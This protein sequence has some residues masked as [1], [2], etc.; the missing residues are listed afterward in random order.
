MNLI[1]DQNGNV[2][3]LSNCMVDMPE[4]QIEQFR[5]QFPALTDKA[6]FNYGGQ[7][8]MP[9]GAIDAI[10]RSQEYIQQAGPFSKEVNS[11]I[12]QEGSRTRSMIAAELGVAPSTIALTENVTVGCNIALWGMEWHP[13]DHILV[14][15][16]EHPGVIAAIQELQHRFGLTVTTCPLLSTLNQGDP[17]AVVEQHLQPQT[18]LVVLSHILWNTGQVL[19]LAEIAQACQAYPAHTPIRILVDAAQSVGVLPLKLDQVGVDFYAF[20]GH[21]WWCGPAGIG[22]LYIRP[23]AR[24]SLRPTYVGWR[25]IT[26]SPSGHPTGYVADARRFE[27]STSDYTLYESLRAAISVHHQWGTAIDRYRRIQDLSCLLWQRL[28]TLA[29]VKCLR[30]APP[31]AGLVAFQLETGHHQQVVEALETHKFLLRTLQDPD[32]IR[33]CV[34]Y[35][36]SE[37]EIDRLL[38][39]MQ[40]LL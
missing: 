38:A 24:D 39:A 30:T 40:K 1:H 14:S 19:P 37:A 20:T 33:A 34:H 25:G 9:Q 8:P 21:K 2:E 26:R 27:V 22:G 35:F 28:S 4:I 5:Q 31:E 10:Q 7:G 18:R 23:E 6:Y 15:D 12:G 29:G 11:W 36:T 17:I 16:A 3:L 32:C 13:G